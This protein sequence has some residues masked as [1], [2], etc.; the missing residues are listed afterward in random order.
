MIQASTRGMS[1]KI[2]ILP[3]SYKHRYRANE[4][5]ATAILNSGETIVETAKAVNI[6]RATLQAWCGPINRF[7]PAYNKDHKAALD[8]IAKHLHIGE[9][10]V[11]MILGASK[12]DAMSVREGP[13]HYTPDPAL[14]TILL[15][16]I[17]DPNTPRDAKEAARKLIL[18]MV[19]KKP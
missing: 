8:D 11:D 15:D 10:V 1:N 16:A 17:Q 14:A 5:L 2:R 3:M 19:D 6:N 4:L 18:E 13:S 12:S 9:E 7:N